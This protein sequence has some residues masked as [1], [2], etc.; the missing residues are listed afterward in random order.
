MKKIL[1]T[2]I[3]IAA[4]VHGQTSKKEIKKT[5]K[6]SKSVKI[7]KSHKDKLFAK[8]MM[9]LEYADTLEENGCD[10]DAAAM[11]KAVDDIG[12]AVLKL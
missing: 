6:L 2:N 8:V 4:A 7:P 3:Q 9:L 12:A 10:A 11:R 5:V 1:K